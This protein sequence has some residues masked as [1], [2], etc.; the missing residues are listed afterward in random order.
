MVQ[1]TLPLATGTPYCSMGD[2]GGRQC[3]RWAVEVLDEWPMCA[4]HYKQQK[5]LRMKLRPCLLG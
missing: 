5:P 3:K 1:T 4:P 2:G